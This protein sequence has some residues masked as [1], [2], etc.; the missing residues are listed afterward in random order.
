[1]RVAGSILG[2]V[3]FTHIVCDVL[4]SVHAN[5]RRRMVGRG[6]L[7]AHEVFVRE[8]YLTC[9][10]RY[11]RGWGVCEGSGKRPGGGLECVSELCIVRSHDCTVDNNECRFRSR[12]FT[13]DN[14]KKA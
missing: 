8:P 13:V 2:L 1:M 5:I 11:W 10:E 6:Q 14:G 4:S 7:S 12:D 3:N 9:R